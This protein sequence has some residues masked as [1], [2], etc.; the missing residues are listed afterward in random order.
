MNSSSNYQTCPKKKEKDDASKKKEREEEGS[1]ETFKI[2]PSERSNFFNEMKNKPQEKQPD[3]RLCQVFN[4]NCFAQNN[5]SG[6]AK[7]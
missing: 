3:L 1:R 6:V 4:S 2:Y 5:I 7:E